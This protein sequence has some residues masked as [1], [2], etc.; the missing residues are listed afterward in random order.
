[1]QQ[2]PKRFI[3]QDDK[4]YILDF[5]TALRSPELFSPNAELPRRKFIIS[6]LWAE[7]VNEY[8]GQSSDNG[9][10]AAELLGYIVD[11][12]RTGESEEI[13]DATRYNKGNISIIVD[14]G[15]H[16]SGAI[17]ENIKRDAV[18][19]LFHLANRWYDPEH[20]RDNEI[21]TADQS[22]PLAAQGQTK[23]PIT[24]YDPEIYK[25]WRSVANIP[26]LCAM[27]RRQKRLSL[28]ELH[29]YLADT[30]CP[31]EYFFFT[32]TDDYNMIGRYDADERA[33]VPL[34]YYAQY[35]YIKPHNI[36]QAI[37]M[38]SMSIPSC[39][40]VFFVGPAGCG[41]TYI[42]TGTSIEA[43][44]AINPALL[45]NRYSARPETNRSKKRRQG[46]NR[47][48]AN[49]KDDRRHEVEIEENIAGKECDNNRTQNARKQ[50]AQR[51]EATLFYEG[52]KR[53]KDNKQQ[54]LLPH[55]KHT[56]LVPP[57]RTLIDHLTL[58]GDND[59]K[60]AGMVTQCF[61][62]ARTM[63]AEHGD[64]G[65]EGKKLED[66][67]I[68]DRA[69]TIVAQMT[70]KPASEIPGESL[71]GNIIVEEAQFQSAAIIRNIE[72]R[73][74]DGKAIFT[75]DSTQRE[76]RYEWHKAAVI[77]EC[78]RHARNPQ[79]AIVIWPY[80]DVNAIVRPGAKAAMFGMPTFLPLG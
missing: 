67:E 18:K 17:S 26:E 21:L 33:I 22:L 44:G 7:M 74:V 14:H 72:S 24:F 28:E 69:K 78:I 2:R 3:F 45:A 58:P 43:M 40:I 34:K 54:S 70:I 19:D 55:I 65:A 20:G 39:K 56:T 61:E 41:K 12:L 31:N 6:T 5:M 52:K 16:N 15:K 53:K 36:Y 4:Y 37:A 50:T 11:I 47:R 79:A 23:C 76:N 42:A 71:S 73:A 49:A 13:D 1:M 64:K 8:I 25:G 59:K 29:S 57:D 9:E 48:K 51:A 77:R 32:E 27:W 35:Q 10:L 38:E 60:Y 66:W 30:P 75:A 46:R 62:C 68:N 80:D 63:I